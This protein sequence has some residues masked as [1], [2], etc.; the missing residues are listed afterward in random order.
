LAP[1]DRSQL[2]L[3]T[4]EVQQVSEE[5]DP[6]RYSQK[7]KYL[8]MLLNGNDRRRPKKTGTPE[9]AVWVTTGILPD[10]RGLGAKF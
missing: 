2:V 1:I 9:L 7:A 6:D 5:V 10:S 8:S 4:V 3:R